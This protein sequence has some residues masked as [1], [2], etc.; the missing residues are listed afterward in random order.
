[1]N[2]FNKFMKE[3]TGMSPRFRLVAVITIA[4]GLIIVIVFR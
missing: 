3:F 4:V 2:S 1:M